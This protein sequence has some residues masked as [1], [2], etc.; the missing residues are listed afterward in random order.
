MGI[1]LTCCSV[2]VFLTWRY[3]WFE[4]TRTRLSTPPGTKLTGCQ[5]FANG[6]AIFLAVASNV[7]LLL[8]LIGPNDLNWNGHTAI[9]LCYAVG[10]YGACLGN[11]LEIRLGPLS[12]NVQVKHTAFMVTYT[13]GAIFLPCCYLIDL[14]TYKP[15]KA[16]TVPPW[17][18][19]SSDIVWMLCVMA[20][21][22]GT[23]KDR[24]LRITMETAMEEDVEEQKG[25][26]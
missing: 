10:S 15:S 21:T 24:P 3:A 5:K 12:S 17:L 2:N 13:L 9:F 6:S 8:W 11:Y 23:P 22:S 19:Q 18:T 20:I 25:L 4:V 14:A 7:W 16:P 1:A 26:R